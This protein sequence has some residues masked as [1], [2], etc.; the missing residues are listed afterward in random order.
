MRISAAVLDTTVPLTLVPSRSCTVA[1]G[2]GSDVAL[3]AAQKMSRLIAEASFMVPSEGVSAGQDRRS[4][5]QRRRAELVEGLRQL[6]R[7][8]QRV[9]VFDVAPL[10]HVHELAVAQDRN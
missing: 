2:P 3:H 8:G 4:R 7:D 5:R 10:E 6:V 9:A 1:C